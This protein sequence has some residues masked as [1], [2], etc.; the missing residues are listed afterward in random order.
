MVISPTIAQDKQRVNYFKQQKL[1]HLVRVV[2]TSQ[3]LPYEEKLAQIT[4]LMGEFRD[5]N[6][7]TLIFKYRESDIQESTLL[8]KA[9]LDFKP[10]A[11]SSTDAGDES[12][13][14]GMTARQR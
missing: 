5:A 7:Q 3:E 2:L 14:R 1:P 10:P 6:M 4:C 8:I 12:K 13:E 11:Q 9:I